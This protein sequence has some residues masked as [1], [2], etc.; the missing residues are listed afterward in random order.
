MKWKD[1]PNGT[2]SKRHNN[3]VVDKQTWKE[4]CRSIVWIGKQK[5]RNGTYIITWMTK[6]PT[7]QR[8]QKL[9][10]KILFFF[11]SD[12]PC[13]C[14]DFSPCMHACIKQDREK[15]PIVYLLSSKWYV[16]E[17]ESTQTH[18]DILHTQKNKQQWS[19]SCHEYS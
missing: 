15:A 14:F 5:A 3:Y 6:W 17:I 1:A 16:F 4:N 2:Y 19:A 12:C 9:H 18:A 7:V 10:K 8:I 13:K 11:F